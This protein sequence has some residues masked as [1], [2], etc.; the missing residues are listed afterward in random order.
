MATRWRLAAAL[1]L[2]SPH[3]HV[4]RVRL[5]TAS[6]YRYFRVCDTCGVKHPAALVRSVGDGTDICPQCDA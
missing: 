3:V 1:P 2:A 5:M 6:D 4:D